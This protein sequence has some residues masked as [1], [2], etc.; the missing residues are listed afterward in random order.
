ME[1]RE[2]AQR[3]LFATTL[4]EKLAGPP[5]GDPITDNDP[6]GAI[7]GSPTP[8]RPADLRMH[9][10]GEKINFPKDPTLIDEEKR[11]ILLHFFANHELLAVELMALVLLKFPD[12][13]KRFRKGIYN[14]LR[15]EQAHTKWY[16]SRMQQCGVHFGDFPVSGMIWEQI[17]TMET[18]LDYVSRLSLTFEQSNLDYSKHYSEVMTQAGDTATAKILGRIYRDEISHVGYGLHWF[19]HW[20]DEKDND[21]QAFKKQLRFPMSPIRAKAHGN[22]P[23]NAEGRLRAGLEQSFIDELEVFG[24]SRGR[25]PDVYWFNPGCEAEMVNAES[26]GLSALARDAEL[27]PIAFTHA[28]DV[29]LVKQEPS[30]KHLAYLQ[31]NGF[32]LPEI[33]TSTREL[34]DRKLRNLKPWGWSPTA[35]Q[36]IGALHSQCR[37]AD[38]QARRAA[39][40]NTASTLAK[41]LTLTAQQRWNEQ[42]DQARL[43]IGCVGTAHETIES[44]AAHA[45]RLRAEGHESLVMK[46][47]YG[48]AAQGNQ[49]LFDGTPVEKAHGW[50][51]RQLAA[52]QS[53]I[54]EP[55]RDKVFEYSA[56]FDRSAPGVVRFQG[57]TRIHTNRRGQW[58]ASEAGAK[59]GTGLTPELAAFLHARHGALHAHQSSMPALLNDLLEP[60]GYFGPVGIDAFVW[61][62]TGGEL[63]NQLIV[64]I[65]C[66]HTMGRTALELR[67]RLAPDQ[68]L[69]FQITRGPLPESD[70]PAV[71]RNVAIND[72][73]TN[74]EWHAT[75]TIRNGWMPVTI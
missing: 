36:T 25:T 46:S 63:R 10:S 30:L 23:F 38:E 17:S 20:K 51:E 18:P 59:F 72:P 12:A 74:P 75:A 44:L 66:R 57:F 8:G 39:D 21:W 29:L 53:I 41:E 2:F 64:E 65:N 11:A 1:L 47:N 33:I 32:N 37:G 9:R 62:D 67:R 22:V 3:V 58:K 48:A 7:A 31:K 49:C 71:V 42:T 34:D 61:R 6:G 28:D 27:L 19:R 26:K 52:G 68:H 5:A 60:L 35:E 13:P 70:D 14:T 56:H 45:A 40:H 4:E 69:C 54:L 43:E 50:I 24:R 55:W 16:T 15:E 73:E